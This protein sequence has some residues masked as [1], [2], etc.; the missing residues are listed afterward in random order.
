MSTR[1]RSS[2]LS[3]TVAVLAA[4]VGLL[5][6]C[7]ASYAPWPMK[8]G[9][10]LGLTRWQQENRGVL[11]NGSQRHWGYFGSFGGAG[12]VGTVSFY[13]TTLHRTSIYVS[14]DSQSFVGLD[15]RENYGPLAR[16]GHARYPQQWPQRLSESSFNTIVDTISDLV[17][18][19]LGTSSTDAVLVYVEVGWPYPAFNYCRA[20]PRSSLS[21]DVVDFYGDE[22]WFDT[23]EWSER[24]PHRPMFVG[25]TLNTVFYMCLLY[26][27]IF[28]LFRSV[29]AT[30][31]VVRRHF[32]TRKE[33]HSGILLCPRCGYPT[34]SAAAPCPECGTVRTDGGSA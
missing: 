23:Y 24:Y 16:A 33:R 4:T 34:L 15:R 17:D 3:P 26:F 8:L 10:M 13:A 31:L 30:G 19:G 25:L 29:R 5:I 6:S 12:G 28:G 11:Y 27:P 1:R 14:V 22:G 32:H 2:I 9:Q 7:C 20:Y 18:E 21:R